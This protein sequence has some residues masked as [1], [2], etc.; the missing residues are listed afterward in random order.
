MND[1]RT[2][3]LICFLL[4]TRLFVHAQQ[5]DKTLLVICNTTQHADYLS[6]D[7]KRVILYLN[8][9]RAYPEEFS[10]YYLPESAEKLKQTSGAAYHSLLK[11]LK[12]Q[13]SLPLLVPSKDLWQIAKAHA[14]D[15]GM[16][17]KTG[18]TS[19]KGKTFGQRSAGLDV[20]K[21]E[22]CDYGNS[23]PLLIVSDL[24]IDDRVASLGHRKTILTPD[25][26]QCGVS[27]QPHK[28]YKV[29]CVMDLIP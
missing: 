1:M 29:N 4:L 14:V 8:L 9:A 11:E 3:T 28:K 18:H 24:L 10:K 12:G 26:K 7:E 2:A 16:S 15:M 21:A 25:F 6:D 5:A 23:D 19:S 13:K 17:G 27:I 22:N 20:K